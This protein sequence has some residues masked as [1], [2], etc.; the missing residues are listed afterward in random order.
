MGQ[1]RVKNDNINYVINS[2]SSHHASELRKAAQSRE[3]NNVIVLDSKK[4]CITTVKSNLPDLRAFAKQFRS[5]CK[6]LKNQLPNT[7]MSHCNQTMSVEHRYVHENYCERCIENKRAGEVKRKAGVKIN[8]EAYDINERNRLS[9]VTTT[10]VT[11]YRIN[12][13]GTRNYRYSL[14]EKK[15]VE[16]LLHE[17][18]GNVGKTCAQTLV[19]DNTLNRW[20]LKGQIKPYEGEDAHV[21]SNRGKEYNSEEKQKAIDL[22]HE[23]GSIHEVSKATG[24]PDSTIHAWI[25]S[26]T[27]YEKLS[28]DELN[29][30]YEY[31][32]GQADMID[33]IKTEKE[34][35]RNESL[36]KI[37]QLENFL[38]TGM[39]QLAELKREIE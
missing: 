12:K 20:L 19:D 14:K 28:V 29:D 34:S 15:L 25:P 33:R 13:E 1:T 24:I 11:D 35:K 7:Y 3:F 17:N 32:M 6:T 31:H 9:E 22:F 10:E 36:E 39:E 38:K 27:K 8:Q 26:E 2:K 30:K 37:S 23:T 4:T 18:L 16:R 21:K 5:T